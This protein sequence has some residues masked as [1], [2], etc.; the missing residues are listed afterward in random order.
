MGV[1][2][3]LIGAFAAIRISGCEY[4]LFFTTI[5]LIL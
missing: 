1:F 4:G 3:I 5:N 2:L